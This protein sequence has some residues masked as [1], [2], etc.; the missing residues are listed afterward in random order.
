[1]QENE[2]AIT[3]YEE[4]LKIYNLNPKKF[5][6]EEKTD[7]IRNI[8]FNIAL[9]KLN[10]L[11]E[12]AEKPPLSAQKIKDLTEVADAFIKHM[13]FYRE[14]NITGY[15]VEQLFSLLK[16]IR[17]ILSGT[18]VTFASEREKQKIIWSFS[19]SLTQEQLLNW[20]T[21]PIAIELA[22][23]ESLLTSLIPAPTEVQVA[24]IRAF[25]LPPSDV[26][27]NIQPIL[28]RLSTFRDS[29]ELET[30]KLY[31]HQVQAIENWAQSLKD[32]KNK[33]YFTAATGTGKTRIFL[34]QIILS[35]TDAIVL[36]HSISLAQQTQARLRSLLTELGIEKSIG[37][38]AGGQKS[39]G[40]ITIMTYNS[41]KSQMRKVPRIRDVNLTN[42][43]LVILDEA[44]LALTAKGNLGGKL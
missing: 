35:D 44:H 5:K 3:L 36:V 37:I 17:E 43:P 18:R 11:Q 32:G 24:Q 4:V 12:Q 41:L 9:A 13:L 30:L 38:F 33:G 34:S 31:P 21:N 40:N 14:N 16:S 22:T 10:I 8:K 29:S 7:N 25:T 19:L 6:R 27:R 2:A 26:D 28:Q 1:M 42:F 20:V 23:V 39:C 15:Q